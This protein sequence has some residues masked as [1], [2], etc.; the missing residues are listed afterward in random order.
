MKQPNSVV[1]LIPNCIYF[2]ELTESQELC[3]VVGEILHTISHCY[4]SLS[5]LMIDLSQPPPRHLYAAFISQQVPTAAVIQQTIPVRVRTMSAG[6]LIFC[7]PTSHF[8]A[9]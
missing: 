8:T 4:H 9:C 3:N 2:Q 7:G 6:S 1:Y 5:D